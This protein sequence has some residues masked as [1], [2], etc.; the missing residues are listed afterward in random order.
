[1]L[2][3]WLDGHTNGQSDKRTE[4]RIGGRIYG[5]RKDGWMNFLLMSIIDR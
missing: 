5:F 3:G 4:G 2:Y 1:M